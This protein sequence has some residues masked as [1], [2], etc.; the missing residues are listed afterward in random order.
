MDAKKIS[1]YV[2]DDKITAYFSVR[3]KDI[4]EYY[5]GRF[6]SLEL[7][8]SS[9]RI[10]AVMWEPDQ[11]ALAELEPGMVVKLQGTVG[12]YQGRL[13]RSSVSPPTMNTASRTSCR[14]RNNRS[15]NA[16]TAFSR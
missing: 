5:K 10:P 13:Q 14:T 16:A 15:R 12:E 7:G 6:V 9:G 1:E 2:V 11:F 4:R 3:K 8:D